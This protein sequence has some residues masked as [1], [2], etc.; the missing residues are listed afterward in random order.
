MGILQEQSFEQTEK[1]RL[2]IAQLTVQ[3]FVQPVLALG[4]STIGQHVRHIIEL[5]QCCLSGY[6]KGRIDYI[7]RVRNL[8]IEADPTI[9][10]DALE[11]IQISL[12]KPDIQLQVLTEGNFKVH[13]TY[14]REI[15]YNIE[16]TIHHL[17]IIKVALLELG[18]VGKI[19]ANFG[20]AYST[21]KYKESLQKV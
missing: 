17:A 6:E 16:H 14:N 8:Q 2:L 7:N 18:L 12:N 11:E 21:I 19:D 9:A 4:N 10:I 3:E 1:L 20:M 5:W 15:L 13:S